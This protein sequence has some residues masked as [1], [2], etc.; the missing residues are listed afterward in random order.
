MARL[1]VVAAGLEHRLAQSLRDAAVHLALHDHRIDDVAEVVHRGEPVDA[2]AAG[3]RVDLDLAHVAARRVGEVGRV[4]ERVL[5]QAG[6]ELVERVV[7]RHIGRERHLAE[8]LLLVGARDLEHAAVVL[9]VVLGCLEQVGG[10]LLAFGDDLVER[11]HDR[12]AAD[13]DR[14]RAVGAHAEEH[15]R[16]VAVHDLHLLHAKTEPV[17]DHLR[18]GRLVPLAV[19]MRAGEHRHR[20]CRMHA[21][22]AGFEEARARAEAAGDVR[23]RDAAGLDVAGVAQSAKLPAPER[24]LAPLLEAGDVGD[25]QGRTERRLVVAGVVAQRDRRLVRE[26]ADEV[27]PS[28]LDRVELHFACRGLH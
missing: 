18:E 2:H 24:L 22:L 16:R 17:G 8:G 10:D 14:A 28:Q 20:A 11:L 9:D 12:R 3:L 19:R 1:R 5:V 6:L 15:L 21:D 26:L 7:V 27:A 25:L 13:R 4:V 23:G